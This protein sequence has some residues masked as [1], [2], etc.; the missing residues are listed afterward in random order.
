MRHCKRALLIIAAM[1][2]TSMAMAQTFTFKQGDKG[3]GKAYQPT[4][5]CLDKADAAD[6]YYSVEPDLN[7]FSKVKG[8]MV[9][10]VDMEYKEYKCVK[11]DNTKGYGIKHVQR[12]GNRMHVVICSVEKKSVIFRHVTVNLSSFTVESD[13]EILNREIGKKE[14]FYHWT[15][16]SDN[17]NFGFVYAVVNEKDNTADVQGMLFNRSMQP[18]WA[19]SLNIGAIAQILVTDDGRIVT[20]GFSN[21]EGKTDG[22]ALVFGIVDGLET[23]Q[24]SDSSVSKV[25]E[26]A[27]L[28]VFGDKVL[29]TALETSQ[30]TGWAGSFT[31]GTVFTTGTIYTGCTAYL[32]DVVSGRIVNTDRHPFSKA[33][34][35]VFYNASLVSEITSPDVNFLSLRDKVA[36]PSGGAALYGRTWRETVT[37]TRNGVSTGM[38]SSVYYYKGMMLVKA[39]ST[40]HISWMKPLMHDNGNNG[41]LAENAETDLVAEG[42][43]IYLITN[44]SPNDGDTY[45]PDNAARRVV[46]VVH[47]AISAYHFATDGSVAKQKL[48]DKG[49]NLIMTPLRRQAPGVYTLIT[50]QRKGCVTE[51]NIGK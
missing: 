13:R 7:A 3:N 28:N 29:A 46:M 20:A 47:G 50:G 32:F 41:D 8:I 45:D 21:G 5:I 6:R 4:L 12:D 9:R 24:G 25:G 49:I 16:T 40:G 1:L 37:Q 31:A 23:H 51:I 18:I 44:E 34:A 27:L 35:R 10:E 15:A 17:G 33:D 39:D 36:I 11:I 14:F 30:G 2:A 22:A 38:S 43:D 19:H 42:D 48:I 26:L